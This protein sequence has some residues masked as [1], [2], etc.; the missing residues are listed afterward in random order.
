LSIEVVRTALDSI[1]GFAETRNGVRVNTHC[2]YPNNGSVRV[3]VMGAGDTFFVSD[4]GGA[5]REATLAGAHIEYT[6]QKFTK[7]L[8]SQ[9]LR[10]EHGVIMSPA[11]SLEALATAITLV[12]NA[13]K[14]TADWIF[15]HWRLSRAR[16][17]KDLLKELLRIEFKNVQEQT[18]TGVSN[19]PHTFD[20]V[21]QFMN[22]SRL[23]VDAVVKDPNSINARVVANLDVRAAEH[24]RLIQRIV[25]D[26]EDE[27]G[28]ADLSLLKVS[29]VP[30]VPF[31]KSAQVLK[32]L[33]EQA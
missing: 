27:W 2:L 19:K 20:S 1:S 17:F 25:Y 5:L 6:D 24:D 12:A 28:A 30:I 10:M 33:S 23:L 8:Q 18:L 22:G 15:E 26:D 29:G 4:E 13:S 9:G 32:V 3:L 31:S 21:I 11:V 14:E 7:A 16:K